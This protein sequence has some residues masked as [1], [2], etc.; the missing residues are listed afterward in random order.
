MSLVALSYHDA[1]ALVRL[2]RS[3]VNALSAELSSDLLAAFRECEDPSVRAVVVT[4]EPHFAAGADITGFQAAFDSGT[5]DSLAGLLAGAIWALERLAKPTIAA[6]RGF[7]LGGGLELA[8]AAD[9]RYL[10]DD[11]KVGQPEIMLGLI[12]GAGGTQRLPRIVGH[13]AAKEIVFSGRH[14]AA[15][16]AEAL[17]LA[18]R[19]VA[20]GELLDVALDDAAQWAEGPTKAL[21][22]AKKAMNDGWGQPMT[23]A[24]EIE[25]TEFAA[26]FSTEDAKEGVGAFL[27]KRKPHFSGS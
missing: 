8:L 23:R 3:P 19:V 4:G 12:P 18:D 1:V 26:A 24:L 27:G 13:Q 5:E 22:A 25:A 15:E 16:E 10:S 2:D 7:A 20:A 9:F 6:V 14:V 11:A 17:G 21:A